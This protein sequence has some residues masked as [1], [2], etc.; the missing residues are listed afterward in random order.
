[1]FTLWFQYVAV[2]V[3]PDQIM[4][5]GGSTAPCA[6]C[7]FGNI[8]RIKN[9]EFSKQM[10]AKMS[11]DLHIQENRYVVSLWIDNWAQWEQRP[12]ATRWKFIKGESDTLIIHNA[13]FQILIAYC[14]STILWLCTFVQHCVVLLD[15]SALPFVSS[16]RSIRKDEHLILC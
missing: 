13:T 11:S 8:G 14:A 15:S 9:A 7:T 5:F 16:V 1:M 10:M 4:T 2:Q 12:V 3:N 6:I